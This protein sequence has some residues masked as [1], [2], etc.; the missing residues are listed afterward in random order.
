VTHHNPLG[1]YLLGI[2]IG[3]S[4]TKVILVD[5]HGRE[6]GNARFVCRTL[7][8]RPLW[9]EHNPD[10]WW[11]AVVASVREVLAFSEV[12]PSEILCLGIAAVRDPVV[13]L[14]HQGEP[15]A[16]AIS[17]SDRRTIPE[18]K[19]I[20]ARLG[21]DHI[22]SV[23]GVYPHFNFSASKILWVTR[24]LPDLLAKTWIILSPKDYVLYK[25]CGEAMT[26]YS[27]TS[28]WMLFDV[29]RRDWSPELCEAAG[30]SP[31]L[32]PVPRQSSQLAGKLLPEPA[33]LLGLP[34]GLP[35]AV[36]GGDDPA[37]VLGAGILEPGE[38]NIG[39]GTSSAWRVVLGAQ[40]K[41]DL[42]HRVDLGFHVVPDTFLWHGIIDGTGAALRW[43]RDNLGEMEV[44][45]GARTGANSYEMICNKAA[46]IRPGAD[47]LFFYPYLCGARLP[48][49]NPEARGVYY[50][51]TEGHSKAHMI[52]AL[53][54]GVA[55]QYIQA[56]KT[57]QDL[58][59]SSGKVVMVGGE[60]HNP[61]W[62]QIKADV[63]NLPITTL[64]VHEATSLGAAMLG[65]LASGVYGSPVE[66]VREMVHAG[67]VF[68]PE[69]TTH[70]R[71]ADVYERYERIYKQLEPAF[72]YLAPEWEGAAGDGE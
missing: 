21:T 51:L 41:I 42:S 3:T 60:V 30:I 7:R 66:A 40:P 47:N 71:Y 35:V 59:C 57:L 32:L 24:H 34:T 16:N 63:L 39:T 1:P 33:S 64:S 49:F 8:P 11:Q 55:F 14:G 65:A 31:K 45:H 61:L 10:D 48:W 28:K 20:A 50:G 37:T 58:G 4:A 2:D 52:R 9:T 17:W 18:T 6:H 68:Y 44:A 36:G 12:D 38:I 53:M 19:E 72:G 67:Q 46:Q 15:L 25:L 13:F 23:T 69:T 22:L 5:T 70:E 56:L 26:D 54:E 43:F 29:H 27:T 62:T